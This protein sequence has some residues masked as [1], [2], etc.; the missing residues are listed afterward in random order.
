MSFL[1][2]MFAKFQ[3]FDLAYYV[4][5]LMGFNMAISGLKKGVDYFKDK[6][7]TDLDNKVSNLLGKLLSL[8]GRV[9]DMVGG[10]VEHKEEEK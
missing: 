5:I 4:V 9:L 6:T 3:G 2:E 7:S 1:V 8:M 10:N